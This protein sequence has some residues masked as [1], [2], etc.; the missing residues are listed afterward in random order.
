MPLLFILRDVLLPFVYIDAWCTDQF[1]WRGNEMTVREE[2]P[3]VE[4]G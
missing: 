2:E 3:S 4:R 1:V